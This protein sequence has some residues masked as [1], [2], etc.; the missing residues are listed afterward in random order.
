MFKPNQTLFAL[1]GLV[2]SELTTETKVRGSNPAEDDGFLMVIQI[3]S[4]N[5]FGWGVKP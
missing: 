3:P 2:V 4:A 5:Y 1:G